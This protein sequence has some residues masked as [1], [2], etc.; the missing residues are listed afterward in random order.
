MNKIWTIA[1]NTYKEAVRNKVFYIILVFA[2]GL[3]FM[4]TVLATLSLGEDDRII[5]DLGLSA[6]NLFGLLLSIFVGVNLIFDE[7]DKRTIYTIISSGATRYQFILGKFLGFFITITVNICIMGFLLCGLIVFWSGGAGLPAVI[8]AIIL[9]L[10]EMMIVISFALLFSSFS[11]PVLSAFLTLVCWIIG[12]MSEDLLEWAKQLSER[13]GAV[14]MANFLKGIYYVI[15]NLELYNIK[16]Q[17]VY[18]EDIGSLINTVF[19]HPFAAVLYASL[20]LIL[21]ILTFNWR[22]FR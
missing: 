3:L 5:K 12:H 11:T 14:V 15:P 22:D 17:V 13:D 20:I 9:M 19:L 16:N 4:S 18:S 8:L 10:F 6:I 7:L 1:M 2:I 21:T